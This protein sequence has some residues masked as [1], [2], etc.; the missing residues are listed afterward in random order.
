M[1]KLCKLLFSGSNTCLW[2]GRTKTFDGS[3]GNGPYTHLEY[4][5]WNQAIL[6]N[7]AAKN[8]VCQL[9]T[10]VSLHSGKK[11]DHFRSMRNNT[12]VYLWF[13][14]IFWKT[15]RQILSRG[16]RP[17]ETWGWPLHFWDGEAESQNKWK[18][19]QHPLNL[20]CT[21]SFTKSLTISWIFN[22]TV[23][24]RMCSEWVRAGNQEPDPLS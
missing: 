12:F 24:G 20:D 21:W 11:Y 19:R 15:H 8:T 17:K 3:L 14:C 13:F 5:G 7:H 2:A 4:S 22:C 9:L 10:W 18:Y 1:L 16:K 6:S 23:R